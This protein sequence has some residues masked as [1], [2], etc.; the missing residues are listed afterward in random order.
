MRLGELFSKA[1]LYCPEKYKQIQYTQIVTDS[2]KVTDGSIFVALHGYNS[3]GHEY[4]GNAAE[5]GAVAIV[6]ERVH[7]ECVGGAAIILVDNTRIA[8]ARLYNAQYSFP[9][10][11][12]K[13]IGVTGTNG[14]TSVTLMLESILISAGVRCA[15]LGTLGCRVLGNSTELCHIGMTTPDMSELYPLLADLRSLGITHLCMEVSSH[16]LAE[17]RVEGFE[18]ECGIFT[19]L[20]RDHLDFHGSMEN[21]FLAK[22]ALFS[23]C[24]KKIFNID[25]SYGKRLSALY[26]GSFAVS[27][28]MGDATA[29][30]IVCSL[31][32]GEY[33]LKYKN[34]NTKIKLG[35]LGDFSVTNSLLAAS[36]AL[37][38]GID[39]SAVS[40]GLSRFCGAEGRMQRVDVGSCE[41]E[42]IIDFAHTPDALERLLKSVR[43]ICPKNSR[44]ITLFGCGGERDRGKRRQMGAIASRLSDFVMITSDNPRGEQPE[45]IIKDILKGID[46]EK[47]HKV[48][49]SRAEA[50]E[51][52]L[53]TAR[54]GDILLFCG[55]GHEKYQIDKDGMHPFDEQELIKR[56]VVYYEGQRR[57]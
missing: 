14:K 52:S 56:K 33:T 46:K 6:A 23:K 19:N 44:I 17:R 51:F 26:G 36:A 27:R 47:P 22:A 40:E 11:D 28:K 50:I 30:D 12:I 54:K 39:M 32:G 5:K 48:I 4:I 10:R 42:A 2:R 57:M 18:F 49:V 35:A 7:D 43:E 16:A 1:G 24:K 29:S 38:I 25:D 37:E 31:D 9:C 3:D 34:Q 55:K 53:D 13:I 20:T 41:F 8:A 21:Y 45:D 15:T